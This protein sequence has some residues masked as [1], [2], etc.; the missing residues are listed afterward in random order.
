MNSLKSRVTLC[1]HG[2]TQT[3]TY[4][5]TF[6]SLNMDT[7][8]LPTY[9]AAAGLLSHWAYFIHGEH[10]VEAPNLLRLALLL[11]CILFGSLLSFGGLDLV[12]AGLLSLKTVASYYTTLWT[13]IILYRTFFHR[14]RN[15][16]GPFMFKVSKL[17]HVYILAPNSDNYKQLDTLHKRFG[18]FVRTGKWPTRPQIWR[19]S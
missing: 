13:S 6:L 12:P 3:Y 7:T 19:G 17:W 8:Q 14:L 16:P 18:D 9:A 2:H 15:F 11:P 4:A 5:Y 10:H 1:T